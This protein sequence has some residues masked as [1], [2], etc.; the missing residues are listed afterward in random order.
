MTKKEVVAGVKFAGEGKDVQLIYRWLDDDKMGTPNRK[1]LIFVGGEERDRFRLSGRIAK[2]LSPAELNNRLVL[3]GGDELFR[4]NVLRGC[5]V[6]VVII[7]AANQRHSKRDD[8]EPFIVGVEWSTEFYEKDETP[9][10]RVS[11]CRTREGR[12]CYVTQYF[13]NGEWVFC[14]STKAKKVKA[15]VKERVQRWRARRKGQAQHDRQD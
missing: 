15:E 13:I 9:C 5:A 12:K 2:Y 8:G 4:V 3:D 10:A 11:K 7:L 14:G 6:P 1:A